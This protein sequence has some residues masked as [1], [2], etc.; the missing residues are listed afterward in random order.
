MMWK[1]F[2][3]FVIPV[4]IVAAA[5][6]GGRLI[7]ALAPSSAEAELEAQALP[8]EVFNAQPQRASATI[9][10]NG[11]VVP[12]KEIVVSPE[13]AGRIVFVSEALIP[14][15]RLTKGD[16]IARIDAR[17]YSLALQQ[18]R[19]RVTAAELDLQTELGRQRTAKREWQLLG[20]GD[21]GDDA[22][23]ALRRPHLVSRR[24][25]LEAARS[26]LQ[27]AQLNLARTTIRVPWNAV[28]A[29]ATAE[30]GQIAGAGTKIARLVGSDQLWVRAAVSLSELD[31]ID[32]PGM[33]AETGS[34]V[35]VI[36]ELGAGQRVIREGQVLRL[37]S[38]LDSQTRLAQLLIVVEHPFDEP[39]GA[40]PLLPGSYVSLEIE[41][42][43]ADG[44]YEIPR[45][46]I[47]NGDTVWIAAD[48]NQLLRRTVEIRW[49]TE[50]DA[51]V[52]GLEPGDR[53]VTTNLSMP[54]EGMA[55]S[56]QA[57]HGSEAGSMEG[58]DG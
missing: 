14:G 26:G 43:Q 55:V 56:V 13:V 53:V 37:E 34:A 20:S 41:G 52:T 38:S 6:V 4:A 7:F 18:E 44:V 47:Q 27:R 30:V 21:E 10:A 49:G 46:S 36:H 23:L 31:S 19:S 42:H 29:E 25:G 35:Q 50:D 39:E 2:T 11:L 54:I 57:S 51:F 48:S 1:V 8:V 40:V 3:R 15:G 9:S 12:A 28:I 45:S 24:A 22:A 32:V 16:V 58:S 33:N 17:D 5:A